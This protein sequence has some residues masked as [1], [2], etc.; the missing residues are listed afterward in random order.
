MNASDALPAIEQSIRDATGNA[1]ALSGSAP[2]AGG[3][4]S[5]TMGVCGENAR[6]FVK[7]A[8]LTNA[9]MFDVEADGLAAIAATGTIRTPEVIAQGQTN[10]T[11]FLVLEF[12][13][14]RSLAS[15][16]DG[17]RFARALAD[18]HRQTGAHFGWHC[19]NFIGRT[20]QRNA[21]DEYWS[22]F[23]IEHRLRP[24][25]AR[26]SE[27]GYGLEL[28][29]IGKRL[30][31]RLPSLFLDY[32]PQPN[33]LHGDL[34]HGNAGMTCAGE[35]VVFDPAIHYGDRECDLAM[36]ALFG[37]F[38]TSFHVEYQAVSPLA[39]DSNRRRMLYSLYHILNHLNLFGRGYLG[40]ARRLAARLDEAL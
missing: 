38:P 29:E 36:C 30:C 20:P 27:N 4:I 23:Y 13:D 21:P 10:T 24:Q 8:P 35:P 3:C 6:Y 2:V 37:G 15:P 31:A 39:P 40:E 19:D 11:A 28:N 7:L 25:F 9:A 26:A 22:R 17:K 16:D 33:L 14:I 1:F 32:R 34:W 5:Q 12:L 18:L